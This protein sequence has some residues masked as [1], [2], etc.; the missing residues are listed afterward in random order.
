MRAEAGVLRAAAT[1]VNPLGG[2]TWAA[3]VITEEAE[4]RDPA[5]AS[6]VNHR[7]ITPGLFV[8][9]G[10]PLLRGRDFSS[11]D[12]AGAPMVAIVSDRMARRYWPNQDPIGKRV[13]IARPNRPWLT[14]VGVAA[15]VSDSHFPG[16]PLETWYVPFDQHAETAAGERVYLM[17]RSATDPLSLVQPVRRAVARVD[18]TLAPYDAVAMDAYYSNTIGRERVGAAFMLGFGAFGLALAALGVYGVVAFA[19]GQR[20]AECGSRIAL[21]ATMQD[22]LPLVLERSA[23]LVGVGVVLGSVTAAALTRILAGVLS[24]IGALDGRI[25]VGAA[26]L[27]VATAAVACLVPALSASRVDPVSALRA[28]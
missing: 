13:R 21:G 8:A 4:A 12:R 28:D 3:P 14:V 17:V 9:M 25:V 5:A 15:D 20:T 1:T 19:V 22:I 6:N 2:G 18:D 7:L 26:L 10:I 24:D 16:V 27:I 11:Q 23:V